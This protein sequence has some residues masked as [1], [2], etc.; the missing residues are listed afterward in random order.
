MQGNAKSIYS[1]FTENSRFVVPIYQRQYSW[2][3]E[4]CKQLWSD[5]IACATNKR[6]KHFFGSTVRVPDAAGMIVIDGQQRITTIS[7]LMLAIRNAL[8]TG[9]KH[10]TRGGSTPDWILN[11]FLLER[12]YPP[13]MEALKLLLTHE[14][15]R[16]YGA[17]LAEETQVPGN[18]ICRN[19]AFFKDCISE[20]DVSIDALLAGM[21]KLTVIDISIDTADNPQLVFESINSTGLDLTEGDKIRNFILMG[22]A[23]EEQKTFYGKYWRKI[24]DLVKRDENTDG[25][26]LFVRD[27]MTAMRSEIPGLKVIYP[28]FKRFCSD[29]GMENK[30]VEAMLALLLEYAKSYTLLLH[31]EGIPEKN[32]S[33]LMG[34]INRQECLPAYPYLVEIFRIWGNGGLTDEQLAACLRI[35][36]AFVFRRLICDLPTNSLNKIFTD[37]HKA[38]VKIQEDDLDHAIPYEER[39]AVVLKS[40]TGKARFPTDEEFRAEMIERHVYELRTKNRA[41][42]FS[43]LEHGTSK[44]APVYGTND[45]VFQ[46]IA[47]KEYSIE[48]IMPQTLNAVWRK[49]LGANA[50]D[51][52]GVWLHRLGNL[53]LTAYN[54]EM[55]N[56]AFKSKMGRSLQE[57]KRDNFGFS[58]E[59][60]HL[61]LTEYISCQEKWTEKEM[62]ERAEILAERA[63]KIWEFPKTTYKPPAPVR[64]SYA[65]SAHKPG[66]FTNTKPVAF[67][68]NGD[69]YPADT[70]TGITQRILSLLREESIELL[71]KGAASSTTIRLS[72]TEQPSVGSDKIAEGVFAST[73]GSVWE[74]CNV[75]KQ[76]MAFF[77]NVEV[78]FIFSSEIDTEDE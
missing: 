56:G 72:T 40:R 14:D 1:V 68:Y 13:K 64:F 36:D 42:L 23:N 70:W 37:L 2:R 41:Y 60:H 78:K 51:I 20:M 67:S 74:L 76:A 19:Y 61:F 46:K 59:A 54:S 9:E 48:H 26:G 66:F 62:A 10:A 65:L 6:D 32:I 45:P 12:C 43:R 5:I 38:I 31:P 71:R 21:E 8:L 29:W 25:I 50:D 35:V 24:E 33:F 58:S 4:Q 49:E 73:H 7:L 69:E 17:L 34:C 53:T 30:G 28:E 77:P 18:N 22:L 15:A 47:D 39:L 55:G 11:E 75:L 52:H 3:I 16:T 57:F 27:V 63:L 44:S